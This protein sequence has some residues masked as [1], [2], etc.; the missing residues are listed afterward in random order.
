M[1]SANSFEALAKFHVRYS[2]KLTNAADGM[3]FTERGLPSQLC[4]LWEIIFYLN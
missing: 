4:F 3:R 1:T 2:I